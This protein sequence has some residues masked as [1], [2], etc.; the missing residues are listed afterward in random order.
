MFKELPRRGGTGLDP[1]RAITGFLDEF[2][3]E[4]G[5]LERSLAFSLEGVEGGFLRGR[6][7]VKRLCNF[8]DLSV[9]VPVKEK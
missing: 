6:R 5:A 9:A 8:P 4:R 7:G 3:N 1:R 2:A